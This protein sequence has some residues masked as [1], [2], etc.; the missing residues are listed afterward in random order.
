[1]GL[2]GFSI[3]SFTTRKR[4]IY[5]TCGVSMLVCAKLAMNTLP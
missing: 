5:T 1:M 4:G 2:A 3:V